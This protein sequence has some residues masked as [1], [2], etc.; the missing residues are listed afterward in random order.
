M[1][2]TAQN[3]ITSSIQD[4]EKPDKTLTLNT[5]NLAENS[6]D[7]STDSDQIAAETSIV[8]VDVNKDVADDSKLAE[9]QDGNK[10][11]VIS[12]TGG[13]NDIQKKVRRAERFGVPVQLSEQEKRNS[14]AE[15]LSA[16]IVLGDA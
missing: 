6:N 10:E 9:N 14:R 7:I 11:A 1:A 3:S 4:L 5:T 12:P 8:V 2:S 15:R 13:S 16:L